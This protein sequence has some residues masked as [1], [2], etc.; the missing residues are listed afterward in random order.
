MKRMRVALVLLAL[1][2]CNRTDPTK[3]VVTGQIE[4]VDVDAGTRVGGRI[5]E[6]LV[7]EG[8]H[9][10][11]GD[12]LVKLEAA[13]TEALLAAAKA[14]L[15]QADATMAKLKNGATEEQLRQA[16]AAY[17]QLDQQYQMAQ[18]GAR[19]QEKEAAQATASAAKAARDQARNDYNR[20][21]RLY[22]QD[23]LAEQRY[24]QARH[25]FEAA[26]AHSGFRAGQSW[27]RPERGLLPA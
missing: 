11:A 6:V 3:L 14:K 25:A 22:E 10:K 1:A 23:A 26:E 2:A 27:R 9:V 7:D 5:A 13:E 24:D 17:A 20:A 15:A 8:K 16:E 21:K 18:R 12:V 19:S 4:G